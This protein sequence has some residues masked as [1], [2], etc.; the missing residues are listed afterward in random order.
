[1]LF[2]ISRQRFFSK[3]ILDELSKII[4]EQFLTYISELR[5]W[6]D[7]PRRSLI[8]RRMTAKQMSRA[9]QGFQ[10]L[11]P[12]SDQELQQ[13]LRYRGRWS[14]QRQLFLVLWPGYQRDQVKLW[15]I[16]STELHNSPSRFWCSWCSIEIWATDHSCS[17]EHFQ[18]LQWSTEYSRLGP[19]KRS[20]KRRKR[21]LY[22]TCS[23]QCRRSA[24]PECWMSWLL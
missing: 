5:I 9:V 4:S 7:P 10:W 18:Q 8:H 16:P 19:C 11:R 21:K 12:C 24:W 23:W 17:S 20:V 3:N 13:I 2:P 6:P 14:H 1:M 22:F 15:R